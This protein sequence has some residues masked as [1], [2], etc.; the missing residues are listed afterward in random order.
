MYC[1]SVFCV[2][3]LAPLLTIIIIIIIKLH[4]LLILLRRAAA[5][6]LLLCCLV[7]RGLTSVGAAA[8]ALQS[9]ELL[10]HHDRTLF[11]CFS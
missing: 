3:A 2:L 11:T 9:T 6:V 5:V 1:G 10:L 8:L 4:N 7:E